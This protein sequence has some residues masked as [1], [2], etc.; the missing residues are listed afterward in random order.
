MRVTQQGIG[1]C[2]EYGSEKRERERERESLELTIAFVA[3]FSK[4]SSQVI[5][6]RDLEKMDL[7]EER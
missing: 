7:I 1:N 5:L 3:A 4:T 6:A 2:K